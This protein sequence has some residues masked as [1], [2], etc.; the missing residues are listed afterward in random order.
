MNCDN[1]E[2]LS[3]PCPQH[4]TEMLLVYYEIVI[5]M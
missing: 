2:G 1:A 5:A 4:V 3:F